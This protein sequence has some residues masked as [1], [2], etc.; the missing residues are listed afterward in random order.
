VDTTTP[1]G[2]RAD[3]PPRRRADAER[4]IAAILE[5]AVTCFCE[6]PQVSMAEIARAAG[7]GRVTL[8]AHFPSREALLDAVV[9]ETIVRSG[10]VI[11]AS[12]LDEGPADAALR[13]LL[14]SS[15]QVL[16]R[17]R[18]LFEIARREL[19]PARLREHHDPAM[20]RVEKLL[21]RG[22][23]EGVFRCDLPLSW[24]VTTVYTLLHAAAEDVNAGSLPAGDAARVL[25]ATLLSA[26]AL[27]ASSRS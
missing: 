20:S 21:E 26:L 2:A 7:V 12:R 13:R 25:E 4:N 3:G 9:T 5:A 19:G 23:D 11:E 24:L 18:R 6:Q 1:R 15:W 17:H 27:K 22:R 8:Y 10:A 14:R 16:D